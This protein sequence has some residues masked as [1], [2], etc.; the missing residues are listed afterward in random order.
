MKFKIGINRIAIFR[1][2]HRTQIRRKIKLS[3]KKIHHLMLKDKLQLAF[4]I[5]QK[6]L[7][8]L[9][10]YRLSQRSKTLSPPC[11]VN[12]VRKLR[13]TDNL[14]Q[15]PSPKWLVVQVLTL[16]KWTSKVKQS[17]ESCW[18]LMVIP[19]QSSQEMKYFVAVPKVMISSQIIQSQRSFRK[20]LSIQ[21]VIRSLRSCW[22]IRS[23]LIKNHLI[24]ILTSLKVRT[25]QQACKNKIRNLRVAF[26]LMR[27]LKTCNRNQKNLR[28][29]KVLLVAR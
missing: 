19:D 9:Y 8:V 20:S 15:N 27:H 1:F 25:S 14:Y 24:I 21:L 23:W 16:S 26:S 2:A 17:L 13:S 29:R 28:V 22:M 4:R 6:K 3:K 5:L 11:W 10:L 7:L 18:L 12:S